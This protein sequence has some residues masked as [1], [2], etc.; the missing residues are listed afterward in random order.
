MSMENSDHNLNFDFSPETTSSIIP[1]IDIHNPLIFISGAELSSVPIIQLSNLDNI[2]LP[3]NSSIYEQIVDIS[4]DPSVDPVTGEAIVQVINSAVVESLQSLQGFAATPEFEAKMDLAFGNNWDKEANISWPAIRVISSAE[5]DGANGAFA[6]ATQTIYLSQ[7]FL[8]QNL[9][10]IGEVRNVWLEEFGHSIDSQINIVDAQGDEGKI[11]SAVVQGK[12]LDEVD[13]EVLKGE[14][15]RV[16]VTIDGLPTFVEQSSS[17]TTFIGDWSSGTVEWLVE[18]SLNSDSDNGINV[19]FGGGSPGQGVPNDKFFIRAYTPSN[20]QTG[21]DYKFKVR[22]D[23]GFRVF[24]TAD[25]GRNWTTIT[26]GFQKAYGEPNEYYFTPSSNGEHHILV[27]M[28][29]NTGDAYL[30]VS[31]EETKP[32]F[33]VRKSSKGVSLLG[34]ND[35]KHFVQIIDLSQGAS[36]QL[37]TA[38]QKNNGFER[39][40]I[41]DVWKNFSDENPNAFSVSNG[42]FFDFF[43]L[44]WSK[45]DFAKL[46]YP[47]K[48]N[49]GTVFDGY[50]KDDEYKD[51]K[52]KFEIWN[53]RVM[54]TDFNNKIESIKESDAPQVIVGLNEFADKGLKSPGVG[55]MFVGVRDR[56]KNGINETAL[57]LNSEVSTQSNAAQILRDFGASEVMMLDGS[58]SSQMIADGEQYVKGMDGFITRDIPQTIGVVSGS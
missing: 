41:R 6:E 24:V 34:S 39:D 18:T 32:D 43:F 56:D 14:N 50:G 16:V 13:I 55:R 23:D 52:R 54:I 45:R 38:A 8:A 4:A 9:E 3:Q 36:L 53:D 33:S 28:Y 12:D 7:E 5:I 49:D 37:R 27:D 20:F 51:K 11:F 35:N 26:N 19:N 46:A 15:D 10:N 29:E 22:A 21:Q 44:D 40:N 58:E 31:W 25:K 47:L 2:I 1:E 42:A 17:W 48:I 57:L 30:D